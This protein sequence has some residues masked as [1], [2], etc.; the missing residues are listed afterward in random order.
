MS[1]SEACAQIEE[2]NDSFDMIIERYVIQ[3][4]SKFTREEIYLGE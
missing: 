4:R 1:Y 3:S 2:G